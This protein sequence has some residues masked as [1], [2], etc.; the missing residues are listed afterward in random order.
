MRNS[1][2][3][4]NESSAPSSTRPGSVRHT[5]GVAVGKNLIVGVACGVGATVD[6][7]GVDVGIGGSDG[8]HAVLA[9]RSMSSVVSSFVRRIASLIA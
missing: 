3:G 8:V 5:I 7:T 6:G 9:T 1:C 2:A 4:L